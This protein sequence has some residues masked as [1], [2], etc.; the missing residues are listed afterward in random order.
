MLTLLGFQLFGFVAGKIIGNA[1]LPHGD[2][3]YD[4]SLVNYEGG[5]AELHN[6]SIAVGEW[7]MNTLNPDVIFLTTPHG[8]ALDNDFLIYKNSNESGIILI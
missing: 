8:L 7:I 5:S 2:F 4:P 1:I 6:A 3:A